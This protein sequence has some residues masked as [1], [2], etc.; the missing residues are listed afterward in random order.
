MQIKKVD[1]RYFFVNGLSEREVEMLLG[2]A[3]H[4]QASK[5]KPF[6]DKDVKHFASVF[7]NAVEAA[8][9]TPESTA[10]IAKAVVKSNGV[11]PTP[12]EIEVMPLA[13]VKNWIDANITEDDANLYDGTDKYP[14]AIKH[15]TVACALVVRIHTRNARQN[16]LS[17]SFEEWTIA[18][19]KSFVTEADIEKWATKSE[20]KNVNNAVYYR[21]AE[22]L[23]DEKK[24]EAKGQ[25]VGEDWKAEVKK[26]WAKVAELE[27]EQARWREEEA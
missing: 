26:L 8:D 9:K 6:S 19:C 24:K 3:N 11:I 13:D 27:E 21:I 4:V 1:K 7:I 14:D 17:K 12:N 15:R 2:W 10:Q 5:S 18:D 22:I 20:K 16:L 23:Y 25:E